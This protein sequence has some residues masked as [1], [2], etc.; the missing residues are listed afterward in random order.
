MNKLT[1]DYFKN[2][3]FPHSLKLSN[4]DK[5]LA[6]SLTSVNMEENKY[7]TNIWIY[8][9][10]ENPVMVKRWTELENVRTYYEFFKGHDK[11]F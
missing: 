10:D 2:Y 11:E 8:N 6:Y 9:L 4:K 1:I 3:K 7:D 5:L